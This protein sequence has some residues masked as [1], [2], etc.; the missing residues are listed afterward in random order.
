M[1]HATFLLLNI[2]LDGNR[3]PTH[4]FDISQMD[5]LA[6]EAYQRNTFDGYLSYVV[7]TNR[8]CEEY[9]R[10]LVKEGHRPGGFKSGSGRIS[11]DLPEA[12][13][14]TIWLILRVDQLPNDAISVPA[15]T[16]KDFR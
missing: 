16:D 13:F 7:I 11:T 15:E 9:A 2:L 5:N 3:W 4:S 12:R 8:I 14:W 1:N 10:V 6:G